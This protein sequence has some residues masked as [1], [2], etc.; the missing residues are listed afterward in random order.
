MPEAIE[1]EALSALIDQA[2]THTESSSVKDMGKIMSYL[3]EKYAGQVDMSAAG[4]IIKSKF[5]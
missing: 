3:K 1:G 2:I 4:A 5:A